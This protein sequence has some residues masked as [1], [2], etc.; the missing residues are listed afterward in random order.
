MGGGECVSFLKNDA[1]SYAFL[2]REV[3]IHQLTTASICPFCF[4]QRRALKKKEGEGTRGCL[5]SE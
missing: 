4:H 5:V 1:L 3:F 2:E